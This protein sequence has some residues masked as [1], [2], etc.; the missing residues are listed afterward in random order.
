MNV[1]GHVSCDNITENLDDLLA[2]PFEDFIHDPAAYRSCMMDTDEIE[3]LN[4]LPEV[5]A[6]YR[7]CYANNQHGLSWSLDREIAISFPML[8]RY[9]QDEKPILLQ[10]TVARDK[11]LAL[12][13]DRSE[14]EIIYCDLYAQ[15]MP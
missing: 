2:T 13:L 6:I 5:V 9:H 10:R 14:A 8:H 3:A 1:G 4:N 12:I 11:I 15:P 7:G